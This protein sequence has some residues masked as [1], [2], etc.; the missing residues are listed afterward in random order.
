MKED[1]IEKYNKTLALINEN[2]FGYE[3]EVVTGFLDCIKFETLPIVMLPET[4]FSVIYNPIERNKKAEEDFGTKEIVIKQ[5]NVLKVK[6]HD[7]QVNMI[8]GQDI[9]TIKGNIYAQKGM[10]LDLKI[11]SKL[12]QLESTGLIDGNENI[13]IIKRDNKSN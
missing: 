2:P 8:L 13:V 4:D 9:K 7:L 10:R 6:A 3:K 12:R 5:Q 11:L 1:V